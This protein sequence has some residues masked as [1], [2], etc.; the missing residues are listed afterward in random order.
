V[1]YTVQ[2][3]HFEEVEGAQ[4]IQTG[5]VHPILVLIGSALMVSID[6]ATR[7]EEVLG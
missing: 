6:S 4:S 3:G 2:D 1:I 7:A 5:Y